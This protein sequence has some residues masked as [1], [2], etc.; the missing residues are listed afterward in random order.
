MKRLSTQLLLI[1]FVAVAITPAMAQGPGR[2][3]G[4]P[5]GGGPGRG[6][7]PGGGG[8]GGGGPGAQGHG[9][10]GHGQDARHEEDH[11]VFQYLLTNHEK[12]RRDVKMLPN[13][14]ETITESDDEAVAAKIKEHV[15]WMKERVEK[16][17]PIR[18]RDP[19]FRALF[20]NTKTIV[21]KYEETPKGVHVIETSENP[22]VA[23]LIQ[24]HAQ[25][26]SLFVKRGFAEA[27][28][29]HAV[30]NGPLKT[31]ANF[32]SNPVIEKY[33]K[34][35]QLDTEVQLPRPESKIC[36]DITKGSDPA[37]LNAAIEKVARFVNIYG[38]QDVKDVQIAVVLHGDAT[39]A[40]LHDDA[41]KAKFGVDHNPN[42]DC[43]HTLHENGVEI[44][45]CG[46]SLVK[47]GQKTED[48]ML[49]IDV[50][51]SGLTALVNLQQ[52]G[53]AYM[54]MLK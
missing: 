16:T 4:G 3:R 20:Q 11:V 45:V 47:K 52:D 41:Y 34:V 9:G 10:P 24:A 8:P 5:G 42:F 40:I 17:Q 48:V 37:E 22:Y 21:M 33:G 6:R 32:E 36:V 49:F 31:S 28:K 27:M 26:V 14:V 46:Q 12:I 15:Y 7:G 44:F 50:A 35:E 19:L 2:G 13:G 54:P 51:Y 53:Y 18:M 23:T 30:P 29:N 25:V 38:S 43:L 1:L 39:L